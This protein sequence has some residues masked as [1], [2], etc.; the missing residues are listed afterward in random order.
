MTIVNLKFDT[1]SYFVPEHNL[2]LWLSILNPDLIKR[3]AEITLIEEERVLDSTE[4]PKLESHHQW[5]TGR[6]WQYNLFDWDYPEIKEFEEFIKKEFF[7]YLETIEKPCPKKLW[8]HGWGNVIRNNGRNI[9]HHSHAFYAK[10]GIDGNFDLDQRASLEKY[11][12][13]SGHVCLSADN[14]NTHYKNP[15]IFGKRSIKNI[16]GEMY[17]FPSYVVHFTDKNQ[18]ANP[19]ISLA[20]DIIVEEVYNESDQRIFRRFI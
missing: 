12:Y 4:K 3:L 7:V 16:P 6:M 14:T 13:L 15:M 8:I 17:F 9:T 5:L 20:F 18:S 11:A 19:R 10:Q 2:Q 1:K